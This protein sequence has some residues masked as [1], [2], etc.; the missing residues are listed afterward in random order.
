[1]QIIISDRFLSKNYPVTCLQK[2]SSYAFFEKYVNMAQ[3]SKW[4]KEMKCIGAMIIMIT[5]LEDAYPFPNTVVSACHVFAP[6][7]LTINPK[8]RAVIILS[9]LYRDVT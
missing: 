2:F 3:I 1:M 9:P 4:Q 7:T 5:P 6:M 8:V